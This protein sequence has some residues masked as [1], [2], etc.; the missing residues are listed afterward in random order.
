MENQAFSQ[1]TH[2]VAEE[3]CMQGRH[4][5]IQNRCLIRGGQTAASSMGKSP[6]LLTCLQVTAGH[7]G[8]WHLSGGSAL[9]SPVK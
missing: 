4:V 1:F 2:N 7:P 5:H 6:V 3:A 9:F 8:A